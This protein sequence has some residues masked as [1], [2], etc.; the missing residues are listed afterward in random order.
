[1][2]AEANVAL[3]RQAWAAFDRADGDAFASCVADGWVEHLANGET[4]GIEQLRPLLRELRTALSD[5]HTEIDRVV[6]N[7]T[8]VAC[9]CTITATHAGPF[10]GIAATGRRVV[11]RE[12]MFNEVDNGRL[13]E[14]WTISERPGLL[15]QILA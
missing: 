9:H 5:V 13:R 1:M 3:L 4:S 11:V 6:A 7:D 2:S 12:M 14:T 8:T 10:R 15:E